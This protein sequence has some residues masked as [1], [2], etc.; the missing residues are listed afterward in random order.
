LTKSLGVGV[1]GTGCV[2]L[3]TG[4]C[5]AHLGHRV[6][7][8]DKNVERVPTFHDMRREPLGSRADHEGQLH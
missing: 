8:V 2:G 5:L 4:A 6:T 7:C 3:V 1:V